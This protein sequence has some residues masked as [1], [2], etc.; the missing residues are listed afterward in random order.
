MPIW[1]RIRSDV[2]VGKRILILS[3]QCPSSGSKP[4]SAA[5]AERSLEPGASRSRDSRTNRTAEKVG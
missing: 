1:G 3:H 4:M 5:G 2:A